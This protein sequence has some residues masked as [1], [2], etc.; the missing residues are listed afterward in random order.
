MHTLQPPRL[1][2]AL[3]VAQAAYRGE[4][5]CAKALIVA[6]LAPNPLGAYLNY[7]HA[8]ELL[9]KLQRQF[10]EAISAELE[11]PARRLLLEALEAPFSNQHHPVASI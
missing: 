6:G 3:T 11:R 7:F 5:L 10:F 2:G 9:E 4:W 8:V 1:Q